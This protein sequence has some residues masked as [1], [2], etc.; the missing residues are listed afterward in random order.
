M[1][2]IGVFPWPGWA[3]VLLIGLMSGAGPVVAQPAPPQSPAPPGKFQDRIEA[4][5]IALRESNPRFKGASREFVQGLA[6]FVS[7]NL[8]FVL[9]HEMAHASITQMGLP[10]LGKME[11][12]ADTFAALRLI[13]VGSD[14]SHRVLTNAAKGWFLADRRDKAAGDVVA[15]Y[16]EHGLNQQRAYQIV[17]LMVGS[18]DEK[19]KDL[20]AET[21][22]P[23]ERQDSRAGDYSN[24]AYSWDVVLKPHRRAPDQ[25]K[26][27]IDVVY[28]QAEGRAAVAERVNRSIRLLETVAE[29]AADDFAW[30][31]PF[32]LEMQTCG[33]PNASW[34]LQSHKLTLCY[35]LAADFADLY[36]EYGARADGGRI[37][38]R[39]KRKTVSTS[40]FKAN[41]RP[42]QHKRKLSH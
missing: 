24:V 26:T 14:F 18:D 3:L 30:P 15:F 31:M 12:A 17:C 27:K 32:T 10:V 35:E 1:P 2:T 16:D 33:S 36:R 19:F 4:A 37:A 7:G 41:L 11:D 5:A 28:G 29:H 13:R 42:T 22:L 40:A 39:S 20:A 38:D 6:E 23:E 34:D 8:L 25:P 9:L 21:K